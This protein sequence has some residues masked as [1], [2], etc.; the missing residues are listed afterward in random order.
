M[1]LINNYFTFY[2]KIIYYYF[3]YFYNIIYQGYTPVKRVAVKPLLFQ[4]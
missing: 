1:Y 2:N 3:K 4:S